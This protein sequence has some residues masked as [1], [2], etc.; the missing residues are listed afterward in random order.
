MRLYE[1]FNEKKEENV[2]HQYPE[3]YSHSVH[4]EPKFDFFGPKCLKVHAIWNKDNNN[5]N[6]LL[7][8]VIMPLT[9]LQSLESPSSF[10]SFDG[11]GLISSSKQA[12]SFRA[13]VAYF[14]GGSFRG[15]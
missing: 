2:T 11:I 14:I 10:K 1:H 3:K 4:V 5:N 7:C 8:R 15:T 6:K 9:G 12:V 13:Y